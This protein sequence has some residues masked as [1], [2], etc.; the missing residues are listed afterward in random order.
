LTLFSTLGRPDPTPW[1]LASEEPAARWITLTRL[2]GLA[3]DTPQELAAHEAVIR[4][5]GVQTLIGLLGDWEAD[6]RITGHDKPLL[7]T[8]LLDL[9]GEMGVRADDDPRIG[10]LLDQMLAHSDDEGRFQMCATGRGEDTPRWG[11]LLCDTHPITG[12]LLRFGRHEDP[13][14]KR[15]LETAIADLRL[16][17]QGLAWPCRPST[18]DTWRGPGRVRDCCPQ[19]TL[20]ALH[21]FSWLPVETHPPR[22]TEAAHTALSVWRS[23]STD[24]PYMFGHGRQ[25][26]QVKW[27]P[28]W[29]GAYEVVDALARLPEVWGGPD[30]RPED[31]A[32][33]A[34]IAA[35]LL[36]YNVSPDGTVTPLSA[37]KGFEA[38]SFGQKKLPSPLATALV[39]AAL[40]RVES[41]AGQIAAIDVSALDSSKG[42]TGV[43]MPPKIAN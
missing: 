28:T 10:R 41:L 40:K 26:K 37:F 13:R 20:E 25:F 6:N 3:E 34:E 31:R 19:A 16:T 38:F 29:Y 2:L 17:G 30:S 18:G 42:G 5:A 24:K 8:N 4:D 35:C 32:A 23:R 43:P 12:T 39:W 1:L 22:L 15:A 33:L 7:A 11:G 36:A 9:L 27:P 14:V 21:A